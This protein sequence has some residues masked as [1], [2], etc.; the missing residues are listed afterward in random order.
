MNRYS[1][2]THDTLEQQYLSNSRKDW[3][4]SNRGK[5][6][7]S[8]TNIN[9]NVVDYEGLTELSPLGLPQLYVGLSATSGNL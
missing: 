2:H 6:A 3:E 5:A 9:P 7:K 8:S 4:E 1:D